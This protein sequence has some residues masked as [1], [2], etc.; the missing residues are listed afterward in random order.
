MIESPSSQIEARLT[1]KF[2][3]RRVRGDLVERV[4][5]VLAVEEPLAIFLT[6]WSKE[7]RLTE[8]LAVTMRTPGHDAELAV[9]Y[10]LGEGVIR[11]REDI[12]DVQILGAGEASEVR[13]ELAAGVDVDSWRL[14]RTGLVG[15]ACGICGQRLFDA[16]PEIK[17]AQPSDEF[18]IDH[19]L[20]NR[21]PELLRSRQDA[22]AQ[23]G[24]LHAAALIDRHGTLE[25]AF[26]DVGRH[27]ALDKLIGHALLNDGVPLD[28]KILFLSSRGSYELIQKAAAAGAPVLATVGGPSSLA[29]EAARRWG[30]TL[31]GF[32]RDNR[33]NVYAGEWRLKLE[34]K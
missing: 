26:E 6:Y 22:F 31:L 14:A 30:I 13:V 27:N 28:N 18:T 25:A 12:V 11:S 29:A 19:A 5:D 21:L 2:S 8:S 33:Y 16:L 15:S 32:V 20:V 3:I 34:G 17:P 10:L 4:N 9:G 24:G 23:T 7:R 1:T